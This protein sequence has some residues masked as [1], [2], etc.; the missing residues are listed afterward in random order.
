MPPAKAKQ[1]T[2]SSQVKLS[3]W[4]LL[5]PSQQAML[6]GMGFSPC[7][8]VKKPTTIRKSKACRSLKEYYLIAAVNCRL[9]NY[10]SVESYLMEQ[11]NYA[12][13]SPGEPYLKAIPVE[14]DIAVE[15]NARMESH[16]RP[17]CVACKEKLQ[18]KSKEELVKLLI[19][20]AKYDAL[21][22]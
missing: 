1:E 12:P 18:E 7:Q 10:T 13:N 2:I 6:K 14:Y 17:T 15:N 11:Q 3:T 21:R 22:R 20:F 19:T 5:N 8:S 4:N 9:C 16:S